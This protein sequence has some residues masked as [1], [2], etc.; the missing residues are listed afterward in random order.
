MKRRSDIADNL[1]KALLPATG[2]LICAL[3]VVL[4]A[5]CGKS[6][7][8]DVS[9]SLAQSAE[10]AGTQEAADWQT[11]YDLG[12]RL[13]GEGNYEEAILAFSAAIEIEPK[14]AAGY[15]ALAD[16]YVAADRL[17]EACLL[18]AGVPK[19]IDDMDVIMHK[20]QE[21]DLLS[22]T[23]E[24]AVE[25]G[26]EL[27]A[28]GTTVFEQREGYQAYEDMTP[29]RQNMIDAVAQ[30]CLAGDIPDPEQYMQDM[31]GADDYVGEVIYTSHEGYRIRIERST[32]TEPYSTNS[33]EWPFEEEITNTTQT[34]IVELRQENG[35]GCAFYWTKN[36]GCRGWGS[37]GSP[38]DMTFFINKGYLEYRCKGLGTCKDWQ[39]EGNAKIVGT[40]VEEIYADAASG[41]S[42]YTVEDFW[43]ES[44]NMVGG[45][46]EGE[47]VGT[48]TRY[49]Q[50]GVCAYEDGGGSYFNDFLGLW[51]RDSSAL[52]SPAFAESVFW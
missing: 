24:S 11:Q 45:L 18:L 15:T 3:I 28:Y 14:R 43:M 23:G 52:D 19:D 51:E 30:E 21:L 26:P 50:H 35:P 4:L 40:M 2:A 38:D 36:E 49:Y 39:W 25:E 13:L 27:N 44:G 37:S 31:G 41:S 6:E 46:R 22:Q 32:Y 20:Q 7:D 8:K 29:E 42:G 48:R 34:L 47:F 17:E 9:D 33:P 1:R 12:M 5:S 10:P 16:A